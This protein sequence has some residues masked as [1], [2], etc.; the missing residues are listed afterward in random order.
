[1]EQYVIKGGQPL[2]G[3]VTIAGAKNAALG[4]LAAAVM[5]DQEVII[6]NVPNVRDTR[7][8]LQAIQGIGATVRYI[9]EHT[10]SICGA[11]IN[12]NSDL[13]GL[14]H[15]LMPTRRSGS[16]IFFFSTSF[17]SRIILTEISGSILLISDGCITMVC[18]TVKVIAMCKYAYN[19]FYSIFLRHLSV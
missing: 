9:D 11:A 13:C 2:E 10:V 16:S 1:M 12:P 8:L 18:S 3:E 19:K 4:I 14:V 15:F 5:T 6:E 17:P 7:V